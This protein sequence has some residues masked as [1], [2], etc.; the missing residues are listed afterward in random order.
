M[1]TNRSIKHIFIFTILFFTSF[2]NFLY[3]EDVSSLLKVGN[4]YF[5]LY[6]Y[7][8]AYENYRKAT[9]LAP[10]EW[11]GWFLGGKA[12]IKLK[13]F[14]DAERFL[15]KAN[16]LNSEETDIQKALGSIYI[17]YAKEAQSNSQLSAKLD[18]Q[19]KACHAYPAGTKIW[20][21]L[22]EQ[23]WT[24]GATE[25]I[26][27]E[28][29]FLVKKNSRLFEEASDESLQAA[30]VLVARS[31][32]K[33]GDYIKA[34]YYL[35]YANK[36]RNVN[37]EL[38]SLKREL[39]NIAEKQTK[40]ILDEVN[41]EVQKKNFTKAIDLL[42]SV[43]K[44]PNVNKSEIDDKIEYLEKQI[45][46]NKTIDETEELLAKNK[47]EDAYLK[48]EEALGIYPENST[49]TKKFNEVSEKITEI[50]VAKD[51]EEKARNKAIA[52]KQRKMQQVA[53]AKANA[54]KY[55]EEKK[56]YHAIVELKG[57]V[58]IAQSPEEIKKQIAE[59]EILDKKEK[60]RQ[61]EY[62]KKYG[63]LKVLSKENKYEQAV[64]LAEY[65]LS[66]YP[67]YSVELSK[68][69]VE[70][71]LFME[72][73]AKAKKA[74]SPL[75]E[76]E[77][78]KKKEFRDIINFTLG[79]NEYQEGKGD[80]AQIR[81]EEVANST[82]KF[83]NKAHSTIW[84]IR[85]KKWQ[86]GIYILSIAF[87]MI[88]YPKLK[89]LIQT[90]KLRKRN[91][92]LEKIKESG[93]YLENLA[94]LE[95]R[96]QKEDVNNMKLVTLL[97]S[98][99]LME[100]KQFERSYELI[101]SYLKKDSRSPL[102]KR[103]AGETALAIGDTSPVAMEF[104]QGLLKINESRIDV[105][106]YLAYTYMEQK[107]DHKLAQDYISKAI[108]LNPGASDL[109][110]YLAEVIF[111]RKNYTQQ[112]IKI[113]EKAIRI[114]PDN[115]DFYVGLLENNKA[116][117]NES[118]IER[119]NNIISKKFPDY[120]SAPPMD[121]S[122]FSNSQPKSQQIHLSNNLT[123]GYSENKDYSQQIMQQQMLYSQIYQTPQNQEVQSQDNT[124][125]P[126]YDSIGEDGLPSLE[127]LVG[128]PDESQSQFTPDYSELI[129]PK[130][131]QL[132]NVPQQIQSKPRITG[133]T[134]N[135]PHCGALNSANEYYC[136]TCGKQF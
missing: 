133:P 2:I 84:K 87:L 129:D 81:L 19:L 61:D 72:K 20:L 56:Y 62:V 38:Y 50:Q 78:D 127:S 57:I 96:F 70:Y 47:Y 55:A 41:A 104:V 94:F 17:G 34:D 7:D 83:R 24:S 4:D 79:M 60:K 134:K 115:V 76:L 77:D 48:L 131:E 29:D 93:N 105:I 97:Y 33:D 73:Y 25:K 113:F 46:I 110:V 75:Q 101:Q 126:N 124:S 54:K 40:K 107:A 22:F 32:Y 117:D 128:A 119:V 118:E 108:T 15:I 49:L 91:Q 106:N 95:E 136:T 31:Y 44:Q 65:L 74:L 86:W 89:D 116:L 66:Q 130:K 98:A 132:Q 53:L 52:E 13:K 122:M 1:Y 6:Q 63:D 3:S 10:D 14:D 51:K 43:S 112:T 39:K 5:N 114:K 36:I 12:L 88:A 9:E 23:W 92:K 59:L 8:K 111:N 64:D 28:A 121:E 27:K 103:I 30:L 42:K 11:E 45:N 18:Y 35:N 37:E 16:E 26:K 125:Y 69:L 82:Y 58:E 80:S 68:E 21:S 102:A 120:A 123:N 135:C 100:N 99:A 71:F 90:S 85:L 67:E 109:V